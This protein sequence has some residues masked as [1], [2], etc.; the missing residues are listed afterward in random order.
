M[1]GE[2]LAYNTD[3]RFAIARVDEARAALGISRA[4][5]FPGVSANAS[6]SRNRASQQSV[7]PIPSGVDPEYSNYRAT[8]NAS[9][10]IDFW[11][12]YRRATEAARAE[13][14]ARTVQSRG[15]EAHA[16]HRRRPRLL[17]PSRARCAGGRDST[18]DLHAAGLDRAAAH[19]L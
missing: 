7:L 10:E 8:L 3:L 4:D 1:V 2:A 19:A 11:G 13:L 16:D 18:H 12:K 17:Q 14:L 9:Y 6:A 5:Q 15:G